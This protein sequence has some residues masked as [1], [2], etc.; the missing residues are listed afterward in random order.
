MKISRFGDCGVTILLSNH[1]RARYRTVEPP[2]TLPQNRNLR[3]R[4]IHLHKQSSFCSHQAAARRR[5]PIREQLHPDHP[6]PAQIEQ[7]QPPIVRVNYTDKTVAV[8][9]A[10]NTGEHDDPPHRLIM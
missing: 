10:N 1:W 9:V 8:E 2:G 3:L 7:Q 6:R 5:N 4:I